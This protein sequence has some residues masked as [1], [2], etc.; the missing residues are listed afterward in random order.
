MRARRAGGADPERRHA[1]SAAGCRSTP[2]AAAWPTASRSA[3][4]ACA[5]STRSSLQLRGEAGDRQ[6][7]GP[8]R[9]GFTQVYGAPGRQRVHRA[10]P[11]SGPRG[12][13]RRVSATAR[14]ERRLPRRRGRRCAS[15][16]RARC[17]CA[18][19]GRRSTPALR[20]RLRETAPAGYFAAFALGARDGRDHDRR[21]GRRVARRRVLRRRHRLARGRLARLRRRRGRERRRS[22]GSAR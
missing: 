21:R 20:L 15:P 10:Q 8:R 22:A 1:R 19:R 13:A 18:T 11:L 6:V 2:T 12:P 14:C 7:P 5:R 3:P 9:V 4:P 17:W 16:A